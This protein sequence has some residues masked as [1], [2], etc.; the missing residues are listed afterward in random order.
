MN[1]YVIATAALAIILSAAGA[2]MI[3]TIADMMEEDRATEKELQ[4]LIRAEQEHRRYIGQLETCVEDYQR[5][6]DRLRPYKAAAE[7]GEALWRTF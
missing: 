5:E 2:G 4:R 3:K 6:F 7:Q 1:I